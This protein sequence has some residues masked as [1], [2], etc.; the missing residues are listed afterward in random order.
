MFNELLILFLEN[1]IISGK[2]SQF[3]GKEEISFSV[4]LARAIQDGRHFACGSG[5]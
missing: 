1:K 5:K 3:R 2:K 4:S